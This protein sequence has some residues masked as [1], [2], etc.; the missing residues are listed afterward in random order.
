MVV[1]VKIYLDIEIEQM[2]NKRI[3]PQQQTLSARLWINL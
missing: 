3:Y 2:I 1:S